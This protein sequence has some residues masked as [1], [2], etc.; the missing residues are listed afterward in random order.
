MKTAIVA[1]SALLGSVAASQHRAHPA[2]HKRHYAAEEICTVYTTV[3]VTASELPPTVA[4]STI[5][6]VPTP[7]STSCTESSSVF[8]PG[9]SSVF[10]P[11]VSTPVVV[12]TPSSTSIFVPVVSS[13]IVVPTPSTSCTDSSSVFVPES[14]SVV[15][16]VVP[17]STEVVYTPVAPSS[18]PVAVPVSSV[19]A[20]TP[21]VPEI[22]K[23]ASTSAPVIST[24][25]VPTPAPSSSSV[26][27]SKPVTSS[28]SNSGS[29]GSYSQTGRVVTKGGKWSMTYTPYASNGNCKTADEVKTDIANIAKMGFTTIRSY[30]TDC[31]V[32]ENV[33]PA[34]SAHG[35]KVIFGIFLTGGGSGGK[36][37]FSQYA[38]EQLQAI[39]KNA[40]KDIIA[41]VIVG[42][43]F[44]FNGY[45]TAAE[46]GSYIDHVRDA[47]VG[48]GFPSDIAVTTT[49]TVAMWQSQGAALCSHIDVFAAQVHPFFDANTSCEEAGDFAVSQLALAAA[50]CPEAA[51][52]GEYITEIGWPTAGDTNGKAVPGVAQQKTA[53]TKIME[54][55]GEKACAFS[56]SDDLWKVPGSLN[57]EQ[58]FGCASV[59]A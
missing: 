19:V 28:A 47:L 32:F 1:A 27:A 33:V 2:F 39:I 41:M 23:K 26:V 36:G 3:Y 54:K 21:A 7:S 44:L 34:C 16:P 12:P 11:E 45:G 31:G 14:S 6:V 52:K 20:Y 37:P 4:N 9:T 59:F 17:S 29:Y 58:S 30:S 38:D 42:N 5:A 13:V 50:V 8:V 25:P 51:A 24:A 10:V 48:A 55:V 57:V 35:L 18:T 43:E 53:M 56:F 15:I 46:L 22:T 40:P 49:D